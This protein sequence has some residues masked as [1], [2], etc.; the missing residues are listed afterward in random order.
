[1]TLTSTSSTRSPPRCSVSHREVGAGNVKPVTYPF[2]S[3]EWIAAARE[4]RERHAHRVPPLA[5]AVR[6]N[7]V[8]TE[9]PFGDGTIDAHMDTS[10]GR[11]EL[12]LGHVDDP[13]AIVT[14]DYPTARALI[15]ERDPAAVMQ[16]F[17]AGRISVEGDIM[18]VVALQT[19]MPADDAG[20]DVADELLAITDLS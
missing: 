10:S 13:D 5:V 1:M 2:L 11:L 20:L 7:Q 18:K 4:I 3:D 16:A 6:V 8:I 17:M 12:E 15:V 19:S 14:L 9:V